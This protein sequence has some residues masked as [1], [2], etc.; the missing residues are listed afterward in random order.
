M[1]MTADKAKGSSAFAIVSFVDPANR[2]F[3]AFDDRAHDRLGF[4]EKT[5]LKIELLAQVEI[6]PA[7][8]D[9]VLGIV[10]AQFGSLHEVPGEAIAFSIEPSAH[11]L[12]PRPA[13]G[14]F[15]A[16]SPMNRRDADPL[17]QKL[18]DL[19]ALRPSEEHRAAQTGVQDDCSDA[20]YNLRISGPA[21][22]N[23]RF[24]AVGLA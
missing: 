24:D 5:E 14:R 6:V 1:K 9:R 19:P 12:Q 21:I 8:A 10:L 23:H 11:C 17:L 20:L 22:G 13:F 3:L 7:A 18:L 2:I 4:G 15:R 16:G